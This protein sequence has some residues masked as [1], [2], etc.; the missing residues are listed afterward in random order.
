MEPSGGKVEE[1]PAAHAIAVDTRLPLSHLFDNTAALKRVSSARDLVRMP[2]RV[3]MLRRVCVDAAV[4][5][6]FFFT[7]FAGAA[8]AYI[9]LF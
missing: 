1:A 3:G 6:L 9:A 5:R 2:G 4:R 8:G 7:L